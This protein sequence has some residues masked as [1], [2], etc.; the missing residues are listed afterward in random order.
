M[1]QG[2]ENDLWSQTFY[3]F[4]FAFGGARHQADGRAA[5]KTEAESVLDGLPAGYGS[6][7]AGQYAVTGSSSTD[8]FNWQWGDAVG[9]VRQHCQ[10]AFATE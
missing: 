1:L 5:G 10:T 6:G 3:I 4:P 9:F 8:D 7:Q 2:F